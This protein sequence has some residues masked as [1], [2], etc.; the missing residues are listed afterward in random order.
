M[1]VLLTGATGNVGS[2]LL[3]SLIAHKH[4]VILYVRNPSKLSADATSRAE[5]IETGSGT[6]SEKIKNAILTYKCD[7]VMN[8][9]GLAPMF[10]KSEEL[11]KI[12]AAVMDAALAAGKQRGGAPVRVWLL[13]GQ[14]LMDHPGAKG[15]KI[16]DLY[17]SIKSS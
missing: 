5:A 12:F 14:S 16:M 7:A 9:A 6:D 1:R 11:L 3:P 15:H 13:S 2:R 8:A 4:Q 17:V 10:G